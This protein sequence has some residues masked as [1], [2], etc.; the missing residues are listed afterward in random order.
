MSEYSTNEMM[1]VDQQVTVGLEACGRSYH[2]ARVL[3]RYGHEVKLMAPQ[4]VKPYVKS[5]K[6]GRADA[7]AVSEAVQ[8]R[9]MRFVGV[10]TVA[11]QDQQS[12]HR[13]RSLAVA[14]RTAQVNQVR[15]IEIGRGRVRVRAALPGILEDGENGLSGEF[16]ELL[17]DAY[18]TLVS[19]DDR[20]AGLEAKIARWV[21]ADEQAQRLM[22]IPRIGLITAKALVAAVGD[23]QTF[24][25]GRELAA[26]L[27]LVPRQHSTGGRAQLLG[28][29]K[30]GDAY[31]RGLLIHGARAVWWAS[32]KKTDQRSR[33]VQAIAARRHKNVAVVALANRMART[34]YAL[35]VKGEDYQADHGVQP[36]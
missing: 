24:R 35:L 14:Q 22:S 9:T 10:K 29:S 17:Q 11:Q 21:K 19:M 27:G 13:V 8:R 30:R 28:I 34:A 18:E 23:V 20:I 32:G 7:E 26:W 4:F 6:S 33:W 3:R 36:A 31:V 12:L 2:W 5:N 15:G 16:R 1:S 25:N